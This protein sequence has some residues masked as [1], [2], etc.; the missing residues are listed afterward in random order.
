MR[1]AGLMPRLI[2]LLVAVAQGATASTP[3]LS[4]AL[5]IRI[6]AAENVGPNPHRKNHELQVSLLFANSAT[7]P[8]AFDCLVAEFQVEGKAVA[9]SYSL[10]SLAYDREIGGV[11]THHVAVDG[12]SALAGAKG[13]RPFLVPARGELAVTIQ[14]AECDFNGEASARRQ[15]A[16]ALILLRASVPVHR[17]VLP[18]GR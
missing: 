18:I 12:K 13:D 14:S 11:M 4:R 6:V 17:V 2:C 15:R 10:W 5:T 7:D 16:L 3:E 9:R 8:L 1:T